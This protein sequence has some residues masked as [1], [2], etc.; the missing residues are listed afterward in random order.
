MHDVALIN[1][2][3]RLTENL[4]RRSI[5]WCV[6]QNYGSFPCPRSDTNDLD[7]LVG[8][9]LS[10]ALVVLHEAMTDEH[11]GIGRLLT[12]SDSTLL[13][14]YF[15]VPGSPT[16]HVNFM[17]RITWFFS[18]LIAVYVLLA[19]CVRLN[20]VPVPAHEAAVSLIAYLFHQGQVKEGYR[21]RTQP[22]VDQDRSSAFVACL[23]SGLGRSLSR[24]WRC[25]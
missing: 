18:S 2:V 14:V 16:R 11:I 19:N 12:K 10:E 24:N 5:A 6:L 9:S 25:A 23:A 3:K 8:C 13:G 7:F 20:N 1:V 15:T 22:L 17:D 21:E 4:D